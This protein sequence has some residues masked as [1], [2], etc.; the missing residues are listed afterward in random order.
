MA[1]YICRRAFRDM[2]GAVSTGSIIDPVDIKRFRYRL[3][4]GHIVEV[5]EQ[6]YPQY[7]N[8]FRLRYGISIPSPSELEAEEK[9]IEKTKTVA[10]A[11]AKVKTTQ[12]K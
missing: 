11:S 7:E 1:Y 2:R 9:A 5:T 12:N 3:Q 4:E 10:R 8:L 6:N